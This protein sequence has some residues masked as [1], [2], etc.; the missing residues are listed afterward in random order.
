MRTSGASTRLPFTSETAPD[1]VRPTKVQASICAS[2][3]TGEL[4]AVR[5][6]CP[7]GYSDYGGAGVNLFD[8]FWCGSEAMSIPCDYKQAFRAM[9]TLASSGI[10][11]FRFFA[12]LWGSKQVYWLTS[13]ALYWSTMDRFF[14]DA[15]KLRLYVVPSIGAETWHEVLNRMRNTSAGTVLRATLNDVVV[16]SRSEARKLGIQYVKEFV[17]RYN[18]RHEILFWELGN[19]L[20]IFANQRH[21]CSF[22]SNSTATGLVESRCFNTSSLVAYTSHLVDTIRSIDP[23]RPISSGFAVT[24]P[25]AWHQEMC[26]KPIGSASAWRGK[27]SFAAGRDLLEGSYRMSGNASSAKRE[28][29]CMSGE[30]GLDSMEQW[31]QMLLWQHEA[32]DII[33]IHLYS[34]LRGCYFDPPRFRLGCRRQANVSVLEAAR[35]AAETAGKPLYIGEYGG[36]RPNYTGPTIQSQAFPEALLSWQV[37]SSKWAIGQ[38]RRVVSSI[39]AWACPSHDS[40]MRCIYPSHVRSRQ[41]HEMHQNTSTNQGAALMVEQGSNRMIRLL[42]QAERFATAGHAPSHI[43]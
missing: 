3:S 41:K 14:A 8:A 19:E 28:G 4:L 43:R 18:K 29:P 20:N 24:R 35:I 15:R 32:V 9:Q 23:I 27:P 10:R 40:S 36:P 34:G 6:D 38:R 22:W 26:A 31:Q 39:W 12:T 37:A 1:S 13:P 17:R 7:A 5:S 11:F 25:T 33:S 2:L 30:G 16:D 42:K 21:G